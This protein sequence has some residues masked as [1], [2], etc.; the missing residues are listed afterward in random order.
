MRSEPADEF[1]DEF[2][3]AHLNVAWLRPES[4]LW[5]A[6]ASR[7]LSKFDLSPPSLD[8][9]CGNGIFSFITA[10]GN[11]SLDFDW[12]RNADPKGFWQNRDI[13]DV[14]HEFDHQ[15]I[16]R[17]PR[18]RISVGAD[19]KINLLKQAQRFDFYESAV[20]F[21]GNQALPFQ[22]ETFQTV[23]SNMLFWLDSPER[24][25]SEIRRILRP[26]GSVL[27]C[28]QDHKFKEYCQ[29][30]QW[31]ELQSE[32]LRLLNRGRSLSNLWTVSYD[33]LVNLAQQSNFE[34][35]F[36]SYYISP[37]TARIWDIGLRPLSPLLLKM[38]EKLPEQD[39]LAVKAEWLQT[40]R[41]FIREIYELD[42]KS[43]EQ[44][45]FHFAR[46]VKR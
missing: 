28:L 24:L 43:K 16:I 15:W 29:S 9:G 35:T 13:Y 42:T 25:F 22:S 10:G 12:Y 26:D 2:I 7:L 11:F 38:I 45:G 37:L 40:L 39:R 31:Q 8:L 18:Y 30:Y 6:I 46:L 14:F 36:H 17:K 34:M 41:P 4:A 23:F 3:D 1:A 27:L 33:D 20:V 44:G 19:A 5:D 21:D 32:V